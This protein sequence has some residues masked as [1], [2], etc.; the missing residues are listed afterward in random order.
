MEAQEFVTDVLAMH[1]ACKAGAEREAFMVDVIEVYVAW[2]ARREPDVGED[3]VTERVVALTGAVYRRTA[4]L[5]GGRVAP[6]DSL[7]PGMLR[8]TL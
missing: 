5:L 7:D 2:L 8:A 3:A 4:E 6:A 1:A